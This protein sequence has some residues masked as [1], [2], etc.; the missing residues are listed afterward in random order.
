M[1]EDLI[2]VVDDEATLRFVLNGVLETGGHDRIVLAESAEEGLQRVKENEVAVALVDIV[3]PGMSGLELLPEVKAVS[4]DTEVVIMTSHASLETAVRAIRTGAYDYIQKPFE[5]I[6]EVLNTVHRALEKRNLTLRNRCLLEEQ[7][8]RNH[9]LTQAVSRLSTLLVASHALATARSLPELLETN[10]RSLSDE[11]DAER[12]SIML[13]DEGS[14]DLRIAAQRGLDRLDVE[15]VH[16]SLGDKIAGTVARTGKPILATGAG[17][18]SNLRKGDYPNI[19]GDSF[20]SAPITLSAQIVYGERVLGVM[21]VT[22][23]RSGKPFDE[24]DLSYLSGLSGQLAVAIERARQFEALERA[25]G[26]LKTAQEQLVFAERLKAL[27]QMAAGVA[28][29]FNNGLA[30]IL[31]R[32]ELL[33]RRVKVGEIDPVRLASELEMIHRTAKKGAETIRRIQDY[34]RIHKDHPDTPVDLVSIVR[35]AIDLASPKWETESSVFA[36][37]IE[38]R[39]DLAA[40]PKV[41]GNPLELTQVV[42]NLIFNAVEAMPQGGCLSFRTGKDRQG[43]VVLEVSDT[44]AGMTEEVRQHVFEPFFTTKESGHGLGLSIVFGIVSRH[45]GKIE[46]VSKPGTGTVFRIVLPRADEA[47]AHRPLPVEPSLGPV[48]ALDILLV[49]DDETVLETHGALLTAVG[50]R[51]TMAHDGATGLAILGT[52]KIDLVIT[53]LSMEGMSGL[54]VAH[55]VKR[56]DPAMPVILLSGWAMQSDDER[57]SG[58]DQVLAK[59]CDMDALS[60]AIDQV[61]LSRAS[62]RPRPGTGD[63]RPLR[64]DDATA[65]RPGLPPRE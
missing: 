48:R 26:D 32:V 29:D 27:G 46:V 12:V 50:H 36:R 24:H 64:P 18:D 13:I 49:D 2:L 7:E 35:D 53:D 51:V 23:R 9:E 8:R 19:T 39:T 21:N 16:V 17:H 47:E 28:H 44:G 34:T 25:Y 22:N 55:E 1:S 58:V 10:I 6:D 5:D 63:A 42:E 54:E 38:I 41:L 59:P 62:V 45:H 33:Q 65:H 56:L 57:L 43:S 52:R 37:S 61:V 3:L 15:S 20:I 11:L 30:V 60:R 4:P 31:G 14:G 40:T